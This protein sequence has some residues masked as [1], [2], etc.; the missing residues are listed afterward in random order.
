MADENKQLEKEL[1]KVSDQLMQQKKE[2]EEVTSEY[3]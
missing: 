2:K 3:K 1:T